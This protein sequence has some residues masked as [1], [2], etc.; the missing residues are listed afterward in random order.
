MA[1]NLTIDPNVIE[2]ARLIHAPKTNPSL[3]RHVGCSRT[4][5][6]VRRA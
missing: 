3:P 4:S 6:M 5:E 1:M 2:D